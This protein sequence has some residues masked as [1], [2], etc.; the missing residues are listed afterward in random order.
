MNLIAVMVL[1]GF[2]LVGGEFNVL[3]LVR[4]FVEDSPAPLW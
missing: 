3:S 1:I 4:E 2:Q